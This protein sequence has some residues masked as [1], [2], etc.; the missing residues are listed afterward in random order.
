[1]RARKL[2]R[3]ETL[4]RRNLEDSPDEPF[5][6]F[7]LGSI[8]QEQGKHAEA[9][10]V[11]RRSLA[12]SGKGDS[13]VRK[14]YALIA[15][16][17]RVLGQRQEALA[18]YAEGKG[19]CPDD[20][21]LLYSEA[22]LLVELG[23]YR[24]AEAS[25]LEL[26]ASRPQAYFA[27]VIPGLRDFRGREL[28]ATIY[29][30]QQRHQEALA[31]WQLLTEGWPHFLP[32]WQGL[33]ENALARLDWELLEQAAGRIE[34]FAGCA[35]EAALLR[36]RGL[37]GRGDFATARARLEALAAAYPRLIGPRWWLSVLCCQDGSNAEITEQA[38]REV[39]LLDPAH[40]SALQNLSVLLRQRTR[41]DN[42]FFE[43]MGS[44]MAWVLDQRYQAACLEPSGINQQ[45]PILS[46]LARD[47][48]HV[49]AVGAHEAVSLA[50]LQAQ[51]KQLVCY[52]LVHSPQVEQLQALA[53]ETE[54]LFHKADGLQADLQETDLLVLD[55]QAAPE[56]LA[57]ALGRQAARVRRYLVL[58]G[59]TTATMNGNGGVAPALEAFLAAGTFRRRQHAENNN[60]LTVLERVAH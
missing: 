21:E 49:T 28:L 16:C 9:L 4:V 23:D 8:L 53:G 32:G 55:A 56:Q 59:R 30:R 10:P 2:V 6:L 3:D 35:L 42:A 15:S 33:A 14:L 51:P 19:V 57:E 39:L 44:I 45:L 50:L 54:F 43:A 60:G 26:L 13:I 24:A 1:L 12:R 18:V 38:L 20:A 47:C 52:D 5:C 58:H 46:E 22:R 11:L 48:P 41:S 40:P 17:H 29:G 34:S 27:S 7:N 31:Q 37:M 36:A 25:C